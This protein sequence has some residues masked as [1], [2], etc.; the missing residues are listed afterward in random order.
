MILPGRRKSGECSLSMSWIYLGVDESPELRPRSAATRR[1]RPT[2]SQFR[3]THP[4]RS[5]PT[6]TWLLLPPCRL[7][8]PALKPA[9]GGWALAPRAAWATRLPSPTSLSPVPSYG[10]LSLPPVEAWCPAAFAPPC[11]HIVCCIFDHAHPPRASGLALQ[12]QALATSWPP[13]CG[14]PRS[15]ASVGS[16]GLTWKDVTWLAHGVEG[17]AGGVQQGRARGLKP[18]WQ[19]A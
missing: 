5:P 11:T 7:L 8:P 2:G 3:A 4:L 9:D 6:T 17:R 1:V 15:S 18:G 12:P 14:C 10:P 13:P 16:P 19:G